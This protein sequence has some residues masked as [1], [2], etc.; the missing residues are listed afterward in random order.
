MYNMCGYI[1]KSGL[2]LEGY[3]KTIY[4]QEF[5]THHVYRS[6]FEVMDQNHV[7]L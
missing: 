4:K 2:L 1:N 7:H 5:V 3:K 6:L